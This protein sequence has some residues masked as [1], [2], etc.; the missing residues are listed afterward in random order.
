MRQSHATDI[1][2]YYD[3]FIQD[4]LLDGNSILSEH[5]DILNNQTIK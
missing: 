5:T 3:K 4:F 2:Q 1:Y